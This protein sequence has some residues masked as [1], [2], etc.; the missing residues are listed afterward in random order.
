[1]AS[2]AARRGGAQRSRVLLAAA[3]TGA[4][5]LAAV[6]LPA[7]LADGD[8]VYQS[9]PG[10]GPDPAAAAPFGGLDPPA[11]SDA[12]SP[13]GPFG[14]PAPPEPTAAAPAPSGPFGGTEDPER[15]AQP[16]PG[17][18][19]QATAVA[20]ADALGRLI[21][22]EVAEPVWDGYDRDLFDH[23]TVDEA[24]GCDTRRLVLIAQAV[25]PP[26]VD[27]GCRLD[28][29]GW[30]SPYDGLSFGGYGAGIE[31]D[32]LVPLAEAWRSG[33][34]A[35]PPEL[36]RAFANDTGGLVAVSVA[37]NQD[38]LASGPEEWLPPDVE[39]H[40]WYATNWVAVK[41]RWAL[42]VDAAERDALTAILTDCSTAAPA[43][44]RNL[45]VC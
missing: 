32:H 27:A 18:A 1:M 37:S 36:R 12:D 15:D 24:S 25:Q 45:G 10:S 23:W 8:D 34:W 7:W 17:M 22:L 41:H 33:A 38:K 5:A 4:V 16:A 28:D 11:T 43:V 42:S 19:A 35:W 2:R 40:C 29:G 31:I 20:A 9:R 3:A 26:A 14:E 44:T 30:V 21:A 6:A 13:T 39:A